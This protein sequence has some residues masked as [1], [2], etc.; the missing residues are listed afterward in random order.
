MV[1]VNSISLMM[2]PRSLKITAAT[3]SVAVLSTACEN[4]SPGENAAIAGGAAALAVGIPLAV[5]GV[6]PAVTIPVTLGATALAAGATYVIAKHQATERQRRVAEQ[7]ARL[8][9]AQREAAEK[10]ARTASTQRSGKKSSGTSK[11]SRFIAV[12]TEKED[13]NKGQSAVM[14]FDTQSNQVVGNKVYDLKTSP[15]VGQ[16]SKFDTYTAQYVG[17]G[18]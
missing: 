2:T 1:F 11:Q 17:S 13:F 8:Y 14:I 12:K 7:R 10:Q 6:N 4:L 3:L 15:K 18:S 9:M 5:A 16:T